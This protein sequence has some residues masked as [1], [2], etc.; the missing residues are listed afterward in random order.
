VKHRVDLAANSVGKNYQQIGAPGQVQSNTFDYLLAG[1]DL[2]ESPDFCEETDPMKP[3]I[4]LLAAA[5]ILSLTTTS[6]AESAH[7]EARHL[8]SAGYE[9]AC[10][11]LKA[12]AKP[13]WWWATGGGCAPMSLTPLQAAAGNIGD[14]TDYGDRVVVYREGAAIDGYVF[15]PYTMTFFRSK[16]QCQQALNQYR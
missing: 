8:C 2:G 3:T 13:H 1:R 6:H 9:D 16:E 14:I 4:P 5:L 12:E 15:S 10:A 11:K 7:D